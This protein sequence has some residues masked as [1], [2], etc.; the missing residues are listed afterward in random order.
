MTLAPSALQLARPSRRA[1]K[2]TSEVPHLIGTALSLW[3]A[4]PVRNV[5]NAEYFPEHQVWEFTLDCGH[6]LAGFTETEDRVPCEACRPRREYSED[7]DFEPARYYS[8]G[9]NQ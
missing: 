6:V 5:I 2:G 7:F 8:E 3:P 1:S 4:R 9:N